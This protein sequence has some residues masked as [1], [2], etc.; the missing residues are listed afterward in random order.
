[1]KTPSKVV[2]SK[3]EAKTITTV[4]TYDHIVLG[5]LIFTKINILIAL[6]RNAPGTVIYAGKLSVIAPVS[7]KKKT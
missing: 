1:M 2:F 5:L 4:I 7:L 3:N 6:K